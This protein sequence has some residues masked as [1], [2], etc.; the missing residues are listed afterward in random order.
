VNG[1]Y[2]QPSAWRT[3]GVLWG[4]TPATVKGPQP[5]FALDDVARA[6]VALA[7][8]V[9]LSGVTLAAVAAELG[10]TTTALYR[11]V[12]AKET[13]IEVMVDVA[14]GPPPPLPEGPWADQLRAWTS[15]L[16]QAFLDHP[17]MCE[18]KA[19]GFPR[20]PNALDWYDQVLTVLTRGGVEEPAAVALQLNVMIRGYAVLAA[21]LE[22]GSPP[23]PWFLDAVAAR[24][25]LVAASAGHVPP[26]SESFWIAYQVLERAI[27]ATDQ[28]T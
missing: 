11:Y 13:L 9:G 23:P 19:S 1:V 3:I 17:W 25:P 24:F 20:C 22:A 27:T 4:A 6:G 8:R 16:L 2:S 10:L 28:P 18:V 14:A 7:D 26:V 15:S 12:D 21:S 5:R